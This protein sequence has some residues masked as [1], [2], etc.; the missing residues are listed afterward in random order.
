MRMTD[1]LAGTIL[2]RIAQGEFATGLAGNP[3]RLH[4]GNTK[5]F[6]EYADRIV[7]DNVLRTGDRKGRDGH[8]ARQ[9]LELH[10]AKRVCQAR[11][12]E[13]IGC[14]EMRGKDAVVELPQK[15][16]ARKA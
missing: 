14:G 2:P 11:K 7:A 3:Q 9:R 16:R 10:D 5:V 13:Y 8:A 15:L 1:K 4:A 12:H 6:V